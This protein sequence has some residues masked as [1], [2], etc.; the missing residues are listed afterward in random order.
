MSRKRNS[1]AESNHRPRYLFDCWPE[2]A[3][4]LRAAKRLVLFLDFDGTLVRLR[5]RPEEVCLDDSSRRLLSRLARHPRVTLCFIS[6]RRR[7]DLR[8]R[9]M[10]PGARY[11]G[12]HGW[13]RGDGLVSLAP[14]Q[15]LLQKARGLIEERVRGLR[16][17]WVEDKGLSFVVHYRGARIAGARRA[18]TAVREVLKR[19][20]PELRQLAGSKIWEVIPKELPGK[21]SAVCGVL[22]EFPGPLLPIYVGDDTADEPAFAVLRQGLTV[23]VGLS[24]PT[25]ASFFLRNPAEVMRF[26]EKLH[27]A[28]A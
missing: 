23:R 10:V 4:R 14:S 27:G 1:R 12:L 26:L 3:R 2:V 17:I 9:M 21:G 5:R 24:R 13:E 8:R 7:S 6:G 28:I 11:L 25:S 19:L 18:E 22:R 15:K 20:G 16:G